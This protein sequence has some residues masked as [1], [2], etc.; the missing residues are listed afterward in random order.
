MPTS[1]TDTLIEHL[2]TGVTTVC[3]AWK[4]LRT[5]GQTL[6][7]TDHDGRLTFDGVEFRANGGLTAA[8]VQQTSGLSVDNS[9]ALGA[10]SDDAV[11]EADIE[12][13]LY[14]GARVECWQVNW[15][16]VTQR[17]LLFAAQIGEITRGDGA[18][19]AEL[20]G[21]TDIL[22]QPQGRSYYRQNTS[23]LGG[24]AD[25]DV[26]NSRAFPFIP[27]EDWLIAVPQKGGVNTG[28][29]LFK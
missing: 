25:G 23:I 11:T 20:R 12:A 17:R 19:Q 22:N 3:R 10:F 8:A 6:G 5:D 21:L 2:R 15:Q 9:E 14:N 26:L 27:G 4:V 7:F 24:N 18:F 16:D 29:S 1:Q 13:G 28:G